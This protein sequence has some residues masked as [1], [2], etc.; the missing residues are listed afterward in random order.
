MKMDSVNHF[1]LPAK[2]IKR[3]QN[4]Y[5]RIFGWNF[6]N[7]P[8]MSYSMVQTSS[9]DE[10]GQP[11]KPG[12]INGGMMK[13]KRPFSAPVIVINVPEIDDKLSEIKKIK[14]KY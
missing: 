12:T 9:S 6:Q 3:A 8:E 2:N 4:F 10:R 7:I 11:K 1:E 14:E 13:K 5:N